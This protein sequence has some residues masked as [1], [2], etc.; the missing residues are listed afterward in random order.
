M[1]EAREIMDRCL[2]DTGRVR[3]EVNLVGNGGV[4]VWEDLERLTRE[5]R[6]DGWMVG[7]ELGWNPR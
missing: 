3:E 4:R 6:T 7:E 2:A 5:N 1:G